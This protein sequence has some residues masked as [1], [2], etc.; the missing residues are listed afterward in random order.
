MTR[1]K[2]SKRGGWHYGFATIQEASQFANL[3]FEITGTVRAVE[4]YTKRRTP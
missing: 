2:V 4:A 1:Y 3:L